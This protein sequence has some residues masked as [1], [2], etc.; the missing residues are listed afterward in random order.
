MSEMGIVQ[1][2]LQNKAYF[3]QLSVYEFS[4]PR[5]AIREKSFGIYYICFDT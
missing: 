3:I 4:M 2:L 1:T 5:V